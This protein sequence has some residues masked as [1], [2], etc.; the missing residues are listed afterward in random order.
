MNTQL[1]F[2]NQKEVSAE[3][4]EIDPILTSGWETRKPFS[5]TEAAKGITLFLILS[6]VSIST[7]CLLFVWR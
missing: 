7:F 5:F 3:P 1:K 2:R 4:V 6:S